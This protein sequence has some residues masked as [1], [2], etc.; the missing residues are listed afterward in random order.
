MDGDVEDRQAMPVARVTLADVPF[1]GTSEL[2]L[3]GRLPG[4]GGPGDDAAAG[5]YLSSVEL[6]QQSAG[7][8]D[9]T[10]GGGGHQRKVAVIVAARVPSTVMVI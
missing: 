10:D 4:A 1:V 3:R 2:G 5:R 9:L 6:D 7:G 8:D